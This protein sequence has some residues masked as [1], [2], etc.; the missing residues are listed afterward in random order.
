MFE[1]NINDSVRQQ[2]S[3]LYGILP[4]R[5]TMDAIKTR[6]TMGMSS[7]QALSHKV[8][9]RFSNDESYDGNH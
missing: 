1:H 7:G 8:T 6:F 3:M 4:E 9:V 5:K 2:S